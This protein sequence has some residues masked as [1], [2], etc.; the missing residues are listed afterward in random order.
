MG[1][2]PLFRWKNHRQVM[3]KVVTNPQVWLIDCV[4]LAVVGGFVVLALL[5][6]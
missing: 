5:V 4:L 2:D 6:Y 3:I 1:F